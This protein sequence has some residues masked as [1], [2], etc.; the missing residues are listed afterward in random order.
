MSQTN[1]NPQLYLDLAN[2]APSKVH[3]IET[4]V[5]DKCSSDELGGN[6]LTSLSSRG[7]ALK[8]SGRNAVAQMTVANEIGN[9]L[10]YDG[11]TQVV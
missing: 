1:S 2:F 10:I 3:E 11:S 5:V 8:M 7:A 6:L 4:N 9:L